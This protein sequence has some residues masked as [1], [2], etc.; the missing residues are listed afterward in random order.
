MSDEPESINVQRRRKGSSDGPSERAEAPTR[1]D[2][3]SGGGSFRSSGGGA[4]I[5]KLGGC[6]GLLVTGCLVVFYI[7]YTLMGGSSTSTPASDT[8]GQDDSSQSQENVPAE[9]LPTNTPRPTRA[10]SANSSGDTW[11]VLLY[12]DADDQVIEQDIFVDLNEAERVGSSDR[13]KIVSQLDRFKGGYNGGGNVT[14]AK[15]YLVEQ[16][17][18]LDKINSPVVEDLGEVSMAQGQTL[19]DFVEWGVKTYPADHY[20]LILSDHGM[21]WIG[22]FSDPAP[23]SRDPG[24]APLISLLDGDFLYLSEID[25]SLT[26]IQKDTGIEKFDMIGMD[27]C[28]MSQLEVYAALEPHAH[29]AVASEETE[30]GLGWAYTGFLQTLSDNPD[31]SAADLSASVVHSYIDQDQRIVDDQARDE[32]LRENSPLGDFFGGETSAKQLAKQMDADVTMTAVD[33]GALPELMQRYNDFLLAL[34]NEDQA[35]VASAR[36][37]AQSY[38]N[39]FGDK[40]PPNYI[41]LGNFVQMVAKNI[42]SESLTQAADRVMTALNAAVVA[43]KHGS[44]KPGSTGIAIYFPNSSLYRLPGTGMKSYTKIAERFVNE[45]L[46]DDFLGFHYNKRSFNADDTQPVVPDPNSASS[47]APGAGSISISNMTVSSKSADPQHPVK[48]SAE[49]S[50]AKIGYTYLMIGLYD[51]KS[52]SILLADSDYLESSKTLNLNGVYYPQWPTKNFVMNYEWNV[53]VFSISDGTTSTMALF[54]PESYGVSADEAIY[55][56]AGTY[57]FADGGDPL[58]ARLRFQ[59]GKLIQVLGYNGSAET[60]APAEISPQS[61]DTF[62]VLQKWMEL[63]A[64]GNISTTTSEPGETLTFGDAPFTWKEVFAPAGDYVVGFIVEDYDGNQ[65]A[66][67]ANIVVK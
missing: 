12:Q 34:Q 19:V 9:D 10:P 5:G 38:S 55:A 49:I 14:S 57:T 33:L 53:G 8:G 29:Y 25:A 65:K 32:F 4:P 63:D 24:K 21:G 50:G 43:E 62:T 51:K 52:N 17:D 48:L 59:N 67:Y 7:I 61:G 58:Y 13:V 26:K 11:L 1:G 47:R 22:G 18:D 39:V 28:L 54:S 30:P 64:Q 42:G 36:T 46:W 56:V 41:D 44:T 66:A 16:D 60:G 6:G 31:I 37:H 27:A 15:R 40:V 3:G 45:S 35:Q 20:V 2:S 23:V